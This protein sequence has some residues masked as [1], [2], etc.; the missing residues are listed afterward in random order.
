MHNTIGKAAIKI[1]CVQTIPGEE[2]K[3]KHLFD[4]AA[5][6]LRRKMAFKAFGSFDIVYIY[7]TDDFESDLTKAGPI[8]GVLKSNLFLC[9][10]YLGHSIERTFLQIEN[11]AFTAFVLVKISPG[12]QKSFPDIERKF[13]KF[14]DKQY[15]SFSLLG[16]L[17]W[18]E[19]IILIS[20]ESINAV[21]E[22]IFSIGEIVYRQ[23]KSYYSVLMKSLSFIYHGRVEGIRIITS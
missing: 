22:S 14:L 16:S 10:E 17:G 4:K 2:L 13:R 6:D 12:L 11:N 3:V 9:H 1:A 18:N 5:K 19:M 15:S 7:E 21:I 20:S 23:R 8:P